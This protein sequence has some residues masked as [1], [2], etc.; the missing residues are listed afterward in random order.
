MDGVNNS[1][2]RYLRA[3]NHSSK[4]TLAGGGSKASAAT[5]GA[6]VS[7]NPSQTRLM[8]LEVVRNL[9]ILQRKKNQTS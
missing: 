9:K 5:L 8:Q 1:S 6:S 7:R 2:S 3:R 4:S